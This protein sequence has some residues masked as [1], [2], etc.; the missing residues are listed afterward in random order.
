MPKKQPAEQWEVALVRDTGAA[1]KR[2]RGTKSARELSD[3]T[4]DLGRRI[5]PTV[6]AKLDS[7][8]RAAMLTVSELLVLAAALNVPPILLLFGDG[9]P[10]GEVEYLP[11]RT[12][13]TWRAAQWFSGESPLPAGPD[14]TAS[15]PNTGTELVA[16]V[17]GLADAVRNLSDAAAWVDAGEEHGESESFV[18]DQLQ[19]NVATLA[20]RVAKLQ[21]ELQKGGQR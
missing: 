9:Y 11:G 21:E 8:H 2:A 4:A 10:G 7:G 12:A 14:G 1:M 6:I 15:P 19:H 5:S 17:R 16:A 13:S 20:A 3:E 18:R